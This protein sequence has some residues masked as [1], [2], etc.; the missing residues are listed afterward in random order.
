MSLAASSAFAGVI[1]LFAPRWSCGPHGEGH[2]WLPSGFAV[3][4]SAPTTLPVTLP[5]AMP[6]ATP[7]TNPDLTKS[8]RETSPAGAV[9]S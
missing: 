2:H 3:C 4:A 1:R 9:S 5:A 7:A 8:R 6:A